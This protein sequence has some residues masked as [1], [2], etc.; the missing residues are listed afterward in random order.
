MVEWRI[1]SGYYRMSCLINGFHN[2][3]EA[4]RRDNELVKQVVRQDRDEA[5]RADNVIDTFII[6]VTKHRRRDT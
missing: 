3:T 6:T 4:K 5:Y 2:Y 1:K